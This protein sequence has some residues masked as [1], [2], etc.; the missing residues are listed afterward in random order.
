MK[1]MKL[2]NKI[3]WITAGIIVLCTL[4]VMIKMRVEANKYLKELKVGNKTW[5]EENIPLT[6]FTIIEA[7]KH[8]VVNWHKGSPK[9]TVRVEEN[10]KQYVKVEQDG[11][12][13]RVKM[14]SLTNYRINE[15]IRIDLYSD[16]LSEI[17]M[18]GFV[19]F[20]MKDSLRVQQFKVNIENHANASLWIIANQVNMQ[21]NDFC[22]VSLKGSTDYLK[23]DMDDHSSLS[24][25]N[26]EVNKCDLEMGD[27]SEARVNVKIHLNAE[28]TDHSNLTY[29]ENPQLETH[30][31]NR[32][33]SEIQPAK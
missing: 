33:F 17:F 18:N 32:E 30:L 8:F 23:L 5:V 31:I 15:S 11:Q 19:E 24:A 4:I 3:S 6:E 7:G 26:F 1:Q 14:D 28:C 22:E 12:R 10:L 27:F 20:K 21:L 2:S 29:S 25:K 9:A 16:S 13:I